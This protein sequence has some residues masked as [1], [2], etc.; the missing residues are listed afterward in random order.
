M[1]DLIKNATPMMRQYLEIKAKYPDTLVLY[2]LG[3][4]Y[5]LFYDDA[6][7]IAR[8]LDLTL[9]R[10]GTNNGE[11]IPMAG[12]PF[13][14][15]DNYIARLIKMGESCV[16][17]EQKGTPGKNMVR[18]VSKII[19]P[20]TVTDEGI[21]PD[22]QDNLIACVYKGKNY[23]GFS[24]LSLGSGLFKVALCSD[25]KELQL[26]LEK[27]SPIEI[28][29]PENFAYR[30]IIDSIS[31]KKALAPWNF[32]LQTCYKELCKQFS[33]NSLFGFDI[34]DL[35]DGICAAGALLT[36][37]KGTQNVPLEHIT[38]ISRDDNSS[39]ALLDNT[40]QKNLELL[41]NLKGEKQGSL[42]SVLE[43]ASTPMGQRLLRQMIVQPLRDNNEVNRRLD[44]V[45]ALK[46]T[47]IE[48]IEQILQSI[49]D[50]QRI[51]ARIGLCSS[52][53]KDLST[54]RD[55]LSVIPK[56]K[57]LLASS[58]KDAL[59]SFNQNLN[60]LTEVY[61][62][63]KVSIQDNP[64][65]LIRD[66]NVIA[67]GYN[68]ELDELRALMNG[69]EV[70]LNEIEQREK[71]QTGIPT[72][73]VN[74]NSVHGFYIEVSK[75]QADKVPDYYIRRQTLKNNERYITPELKELEQKALSAQERAL[76]LETQIFIEIVKTLQQSINELITLS[77]L[78]ALLDV[79]TSFAIIAKDRNYVRPVLT[80]NH[81]L[82]IVDGRHPVI[83][84]LT[85]TP[86]VANSIDLSQKN[87]LVI[88]G[89]N[90][91]GKSTY[92]RQTALISIM[93]RIGSFVPAREAIIGNIDRIFTRIGASDDLISGRST[94]MVEME[95]TSSIINN[96]T[97]NSLVLM[98]EIGR[99]TS[100]YEGGA[101]ALA[102][103]EHMCSTI[104][105]FTLFATHYPEIAKLSD[106]YPNLENICFKASECLG[107]IVF[108]YQACSGSQNYS[109]AVE[110]GKLAGL[111]EDIITKAKDYIQKIQTISSKEVKAK[112][113]TK[114]TQSSKT[115][116][117]QVI[118]KIVEKVKPSEVEQKLKA[119]DINELTPRDALNLL[120]DLKAL[121]K[122]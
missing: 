27:V 63:L 108:L 10:R 105:C 111:P 92:M 23:F 58:S 104:N 18:E 109:Y 47:A 33:T 3:D 37:V 13:H 96:A 73:K 46:D 83:E 20:G 9:T 122:E 49:G 61:N 77:S 117:S 74:Y 6:K 4:F 71:E 76:A 97:V 88:T 103:A 28:V 22:Q 21:A 54:L 41:S 32:D 39:F 106:T 68:S 86:F 102:I 24:Y 38:K 116:E 114:D 55:S 34:E 60:P 79:L 42:I 67:P 19:T 112:A 66:G 107:K 75:A 118:E 70:L 56:L 120:Y 25:L 1:E 84:T 31:S 59:T 82:K 2:R 26:Y 44:L 69:S 93:A 8:L 43:G 17:C 98:D 57:E 30:N 91:G 113:V 16:I 36:Y 110:V 95:E 5:E 7:K 121:I 78:I 62:L 87:M 48:P 85:D 11:P 101:L 51:S 53:P 29:Y 100:T 14:A 119:I 99:G 12:V 64:S 89:P 81:E 65:T 52:R 90:M 15:V 50:I 45:E 72:L 35:E 115:T 94:F 80:N 40:A